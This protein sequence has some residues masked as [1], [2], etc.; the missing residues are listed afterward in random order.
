MSTIEAKLVLTEAEWQRQVLPE[1]YAL[2]TWAELGDTVATR[3]CFYHLMSECYLDDPTNPLGLRPPR[4]K[5]E[6][7]VLGDPNFTPEGCFIL[8]HEQVWVGL[9][10]LNRLNETEAWAAFTGLLPAHR[11]KGLASALKIETI[12]WARESGL[13][14]IITRVATSNGVMR[15]LNLQ[16]GFRECSAE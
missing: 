10:L 8:L 12:C 11:G 4:A 2:T 15:Q 16:L 5:F 1:S 7:Q 6:S 3:S 9:A 14:V 13:S